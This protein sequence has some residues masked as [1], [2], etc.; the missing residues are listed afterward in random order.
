MTEAKIDTEKTD[1]DVEGS[2]APLLDHLN[3]LRRRLIISILAI[4]IGF[5]ICLFFVR[6]IFDMLVMPFE[7]DLKVI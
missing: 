1:E 4:I 6:P 5:T 7:R 2:R 3:E